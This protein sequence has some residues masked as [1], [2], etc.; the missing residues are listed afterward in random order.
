MKTALT[1]QREALY[2]FASGR[3]HPSTGLLYDHI[4]DPADEKHFPAVETIQKGIL[5]PRPDGRPNYSGYG[6]GQEDC[7]LTG[8][9]LLDAIVCRHEA[10][11][12]C[13]Y[14]SLAKKAAGG[15]I[16]NA[17]AG[18]NG[19]LPRGLSPRDGEAHFIESSIDQYTMFFYG[20]TR[21][22]MS[23]LCGEEDRAAA[24]TA[25]IRIAQRAVRNVR[26]ETGYDMLRE[27]DGPTLVT[28]LWGPDLKNHE[29]MRLPMF[30]LCTWLLSG[31]SRWLDLYSSL[32]GEGLERSLP[33]TQYW[34]L[35]TLQQMAASVNITYLYD[36]DESR[37]EKAGHILDEIA[38]YAETRIQP[39]RG[40]LIRTAPSDWKR[41][42]E[43]DPFYRIQDAAI[44]PLV[45][46]LSPNYGISAQSVSLC[47]ETLSRI[48]LSVHETSL[49]IHFLCA[50][51]HIAAAV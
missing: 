27:D 51:E 48:D 19:F 23:E 31:D 44:I 18:K 3:I 39:L 33:M 17:L 43:A 50:A 45:Q 38:A 1:E 25:F 4:Y 41:R 21:F 9:T 28:K 15:M 14:C 26:E 20:I 12:S 35:Y 30:F 40:E 32:C 34:H 16:R 6:T 37:R 49:P 36:P 42:D 8:G 13:R 10:G 11:G 29:I 7:S 47:E 46:S 5:P 22:A 2:R 24:K